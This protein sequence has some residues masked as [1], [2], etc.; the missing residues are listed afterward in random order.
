[1]IN[2]PITIRLRHA[3]RSLRAAL[4]E[5]R[6]ARLHISDAWRCLTGAAFAVLVVVL[7]FPS[8]ALAQPVDAVEPSALAQ[9][10]TSG[11]LWVT[12]GA[13]VV[14]LTWVGERLLASKTPILEQLKHMA[15]SAIPG[16]IAGATVGGG[17]LLEG[18]GPLMALTAFLTIALIGANVRKP[19]AT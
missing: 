16:I 1:M 4:T 10:M 5:R 18:K 17:V 6:L 13:V 12:I 2:V 11:S 8:M 9:A 15:Q 14:V 7:L 3:G 19:V